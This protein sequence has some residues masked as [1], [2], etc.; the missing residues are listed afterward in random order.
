MACAPIDIEGR[1]Q[2]CTEQATRYQSAQCDDGEPLLRGRAFAK[3][4]RGW[5]QTYPAI[6]HD[7]D[8]FQLLDGQV[9]RTFQSNEN[10]QVA[11]S[12]WNRCNSLSRQQDVQLR[13]QWCWR[14]AMKGETGRLGCDG[15]CCPI[16]SRLLTVT[17][18]FSA[19]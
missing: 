3:T 5:K 1:Q 19:I 13:K 18:G 16:L 14:G 10:I 15:T 11:V 9:C 7:R 6:C 2:V 17:A 12:L 8:L 4:E